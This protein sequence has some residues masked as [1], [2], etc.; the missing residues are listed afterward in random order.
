[1][2]IIFTLSRLT[3]HLFLFAPCRWS[4][5]Q[6]LQEIKELLGPSS[7]AFSSS[8]SSS[9]ASSSSTHVM[10]MEVRHTCSRRQTGKRT[11]ICHMMNI[12]TPYDM[13]P[14]S[15][16]FPTHLSAHWSPRPPGPA[17]TAKC[18]QPKPSTCH[19]REPS[20]SCQHLQDLQHLQNL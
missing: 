4:E 5:V 8:S 18:S 14:K 11:A 12:M 16:R 7:S 13:Q 2:K 19:W 10:V 15:L 1:M 17:A 6:Q 9:G 20:G 3:K